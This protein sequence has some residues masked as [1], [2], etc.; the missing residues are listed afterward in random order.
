MQIGLMCCKNTFFTS[1]MCQY[2]IFLSA[3]QES[4]SQDK[5][6]FQCLISVFTE[7]GKIEKLHS[8]FGRSIV[9]KGSCVKL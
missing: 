9:T 1:F 5:S 4:Y 3:F 8:V 2:Q 7:V 6:R